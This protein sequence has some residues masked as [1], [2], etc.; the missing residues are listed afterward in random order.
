MSKGVSSIGSCISFSAILPE[1]LNQA[2]F[3]GLTEFEDSGEATNIGDVG[4]EHEVI[5]FPTV[6]DGKINKRMGATNFG[7]QNL[8]LAFDKKN[9]AQAILKTASREKNPVAVRETL[10]SGDIYYYIAYIAK[11]KTQVGGSSDYLRAAV[12]LEIDSE[13]VEVDAVVAA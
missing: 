9:N 10:S 6:C 5:T 13:I 7:Q 8:L 1:T 4:E 11:F 2:G 12:D 3:E